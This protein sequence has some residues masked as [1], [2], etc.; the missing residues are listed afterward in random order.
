MQNDNRVDRNRAAVEQFLRALRRG[1][2]EE[3]SDCLQADAVWNIPRSG[4]RPSPRGA[5]EIVALLTEAPGDFYRP[6]TI[7]ME[8]DFLVVDEKHAAL[9]FRMR[10]TTASGLPYD[11]IYVFS[12]RFVDGRIAE[13]WEHTD[14]AYWQRTVLEGG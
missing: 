11:N 12:F 5:E 2:R 3:L 9:Q 10:C 13:G 8:P 4:G 1:D 14:T 6:E 7:R